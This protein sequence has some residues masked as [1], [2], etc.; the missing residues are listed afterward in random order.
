MSRRRLRESCGEVQPGQGYHDMCAARGQ[1]SSSSEAT[2]MA[3]K[4]PGLTITTTYVGYRFTYGVGTVG[5]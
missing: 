2:T 5:C 4:D 3:P 1:S